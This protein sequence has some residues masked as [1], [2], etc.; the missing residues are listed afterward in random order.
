MNRR[1][2][3]DWRTRL[4]WA[5]A[6][7]WLAGAGGTVRAEPG[8]DAAVL[9]DPFWPVGYQPPAPAKA[10]DPDRVDSAA[11]VWPALPVQGRSRAP[12]GTFRVLIRGAGV[13][14]ENDVVSVRSGGYWFNWRVVRIDEEGVES[15]RLGVSKKR[16]QPKAS[17]TLVLAAPT[18]RKEKTP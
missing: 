18:S 14:G 2:R 6:V 4:V 17:N 8:G 1:R 10:G 15:V 7:L 11:V 13:V 5:A 16:S 3:T 12:D 9:R